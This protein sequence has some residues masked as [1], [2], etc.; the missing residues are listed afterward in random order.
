MRLSIMVPAYN[1]EPTIRRALQR[2]L[3]VDFPV[4]REVIV[5]DDGSVDGTAKEIEALGSPEIRLVRH[6]TN[7]GKGA[8]LR[9][10][11]GLATGDYLVAFDADLEYH[12]QD[13]VAV[14]QPV[15]DDDAE[16]VIGTRTF[17]GATAHSFRF[18]LGNRLTTFVANALFDTWLHDIHCCYK[19]LPRTLW[20]ELDLREDRFGLDT[21]LVAKVL[22]RGIRPF[23][24]P[25]HYR[26]RSFSEGKKITWHDGVDS[27]RILFRERLRR[28]Q[29]ANRPGH[30]RE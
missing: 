29:R 27:I 14:L 2:L 18:V 4:D 10:A 26:A 24:V 3:D 1:E 8:A 12:P 11:A 6:E 28:S 9:T 16:V 19:L 21:E 30:I 13:I 20:Q 23:E 15:L 17:G 7:R 5:V 25:V 22:A